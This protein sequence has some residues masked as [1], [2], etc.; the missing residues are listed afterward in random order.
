MTFKIV[1]KAANKAVRGYSPYALLG[2]CILLTGLPANAA[3][4]HHRHPVSHHSTSHKHSRSHAVYAPTYAGYVLDAATGQVLYQNNAEQALHPASLTKIMTLL[5]VFEAL[6]KGELNLRDR[7]TVSNR[8]ASMAPSKLGLDPGASLS[9]KD[10]IYAIVTKS[11]N[12]VA[13]AFA[14]NLAG[15]E[16]AFAKRMTARA[17]ELG[18]A[19]TTFVNASGLPN[20]RQISS[21]HDMARLARY[22]ITTY[23]A[24]YKFYSTKNF[25]YAGQELH[26]HNNL[27]NSYAGMDGMKTGYIR[28]SGFNLV[29]S[30]VRDHHRLIGVVFGG[31]S[32]NTR[33]RQMAQLL[34][35]GFTKL[36]SQAT[37][38]VFAADD[39]MAGKAETIATAAPTQDATFNEVSPASA[40]IASAAPI[41]STAATPVLTRADDETDDDEEGGDM[42]DKEPVTAQRI[43]SHTMMQ[44]NMPSWAIQVGA[45]SSRAAT[46][47]AL[48][49]LIKKLPVKYASAS[50]IIAPLKTHDGWVFRARLHGF[51]KSEALSA[52]RHIS[53][54]VP[55]A[56]RNN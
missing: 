22:V 6:D 37:V 33:N 26:N 49:D 21:A 51:S 28:A 31:R 29:A 56:P 5:L 3:A 32:A 25:Y 39:R 19:R 47:K 14:E 20:P 52:C 13:V 41:S 7:I 23:P 24:Y 30:A 16:G 55:V 34:D 15:S 12:D 40:E 11:C 18:M 44:T 38:P 35:A 54:C 2:L 43:H 1:A 48:Q 53:R 8:A 50:P 45:Y 27:M 42:P 36:K 10:A 4:R 17:R 9:V 46:D